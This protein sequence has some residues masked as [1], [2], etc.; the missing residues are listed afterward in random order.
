[1]TIAHLQ[2]FIPGLFQPL[3]LWQKDFGFQPE[4]SALLTLCAQ[5]DIDPLTVTGLED[6][7]MQ[8]L[9]YNLAQGNPYAQWRY[10]V[11]FGQAPA[12]PVLC[13]DPVFLQS[14]ISQIVVHPELPVLDQSTAE[15]LIDLLNRHLVEDG[16]RLVAKH[17]QRWY[18]LKESGE[19]TWPT[20]TVAL[21]AVLG[22]SLYP[23]LPQG[24]ERYWHR[25]LNEVQ[26][27]LHTA[28]VPQVNGLWFWGAT[29]QSAVLAPKHTNNLALYGNDLSTEVIATAVNVPAHTLTTFAQTQLAPQTWVLLIDL[30]AAALRDDMQAWQQV[31]NQL[32]QAWF[33]PLLAAL[34][35]GK[36]R[37]SIT[38]CDG[39]NMHCRL[40]KG[41]RFW[42]K[43]QTSWD[44]L[45]KC[46]QT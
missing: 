23:H 31:F 36:I 9:G 15:R 20:Q 1:M 6:T 32:E 34:K 5:T 42:Q 46:S 30:H 17:P 28:G 2:L 29:A 16:L 8:L 26:M 43:S 39:R 12:V 4:S 18:L 11:E 25:L 33:V 21:S 35:A 14:G 7:T 13:A 22:Q 24:N 41:W 19:V 40:R 45:G 38:A 10:Q 3:A 44:Y 37:L 27:L